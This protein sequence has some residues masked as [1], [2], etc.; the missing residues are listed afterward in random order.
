[1]VNRYNTG[2]PRPSNSMKDL[3]DNA[4]AYDD[5]MNS[6]NDTFI[7]RLENERDTLAGAQKKMAA[8]ADNQRADQDSKFESQMTTQ[9]SSFISQ[10][11]QQA[12]KFDAQISSQAS[13]YE[14]VLQEAGKTVLG[15]Y[16][17]GPWTL[18]SYNQLV[19]YGGT[20]WKLAASV[21]IGSGYTT[22]GTTDATWSA[23]DKAN[24]VDVGQE[25]LRSELG[26]IFMPAAS[27]DSAT[28]TQ[29]LQAA[30]SVGGMILY[31]KPGEYFYNGT[32]TISSGTSFHTASGVRWIQDK[33][34][35]TWSP[36]LVNEA[37]NASKY[38]VTS[39]TKL[40]GYLNPWRD[41]PTANGQV[42]ATVV[43][44]SHPFSAGDYAAFY[45]AKEYGYD[46][47]M[48][49]TEVIDANTFIVE[50]H[51]SLKDP[52]ATYT[53]WATNLYCFV[54]D[55]NIDI[56]IQG[57]IDGRFGAMNNAAQSVVP[58]IHLMGIV[59]RGLLN[60]RIEVADARRFRKYAVCL[61]NIRNV[62]VP[63]MNFNT[64]SDGLHIM[65]PYVGV[66]IGSLTGTTGDDMLA[67][68]GGDFTTY[69]LSRGHG[70]S[71]KAD[72]I[73]PQ[74]SLTA[75]K[76]T[77][78]AP[79]KFWDIDIGKIHGSTTLAI[80]SMIRDTNLTHTDIG[81]LGIGSVGCQVQSGDEFRI[82]PDTLEYLHIG[83]LEVFESL[84]TRSVLR[85]GN[86]T[87]NFVKVGSVVIDNLRHHKPGLESRT[88]FAG[89]WNSS[90]EKVDIRIC[91]LE[92]TDANTFTAAR[93]NVANGSYPAGI[94]RHIKLSGSI[95]MP[96]GTGR[97]IQLNGVCNKITLKD[98]ETEGGDVLVYNTTSWTS[99][100][101]E[102]KIVL[103]NVETKGVSRLFN[104]M[105]GNIIRLQCGNNYIGT[106]SSNSALY[107]YDGGTVII[108]GYL[109]SHP[110][111]VATD[112]APCVTKQSSAAIVYSLDFRNHLDT[113]NVATGRLGDMAY[114]INANATYGITPVYHNGSVWSPVY[115]K[116]EVQ[117]PADKTQASYTPVW[118]YGHVYQ[119][120]PLGQN[121]TFVATSDSLSSLSVGDKVSIIVTQDSVGGRTVSFSG[122]F[123]F[124]QNMT[125]SGLAGTTSVY[126][127]IFN[128]SKL[129]CLSANSWV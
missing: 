75:L 109:N 70:Y 129:V 48:F 25:Q 76:V 110:E 9:Q 69:E 114:N 55:K 98:L 36:L 79:H 84:A 103:D 21:V 45:G 32:G 78:N 105:G 87:D 19:S 42:Y 27:G 51:S 94:V 113:V 91:N 10:L 124:A 37:L 63:R 71:I 93:T 102:L 58:A 13:R 65:P 46:G 31:N 126:D 59:M 53:E 106:K 6:E 38:V 11:N 118:K 108:E 83:D 57:T 121:V 17:D 7:D 8:A 54:P 123:A 16:E 89:G 92:L 73:S 61:A 18:T 95:K 72:N 40:T 26:T 41:N 47:I 112:L 12:Q 82:L 127:F 80:V 14:A 39:M 29:L 104:V 90:T 44:P 86:S 111:A 96:N 122:L 50:S 56:N 81:R 60:S 64:Y 4:L 5:F 119:M 77:G 24:F 128:G 28:D 2:N 99:E 3:S 15:R 107:V 100:T 67:L 34:A 35:E 52:Q 85:V 120:S 97:P 23:T 101:G 22:A 43:C 66:N 88:L 30:L 68:T 49:V 1:M 74:N 20:F 33:N 62:E 116:A 117:V 115:Y 125:A